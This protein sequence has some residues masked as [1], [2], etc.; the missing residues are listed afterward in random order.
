MKRKLDFFFKTLETPCSLTEF[1]PNDRVNTKLR[2]QSAPKPT[3]STEYYGGR[4]VT[5]FTE[6]V[7]T[8][9]SNL[10]QQS[11]SPNANKSQLSEASYQNN[12]TTDIT[13]WLKGFLNPQRNSSY[14][15]S[16]Q[17]NGNAKL[18]ISPGKSSAGKVINLE[19]F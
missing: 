4:G 13:V 14:E 6:N 18:F 2:C 1:Y 9:F 10:E 19:Q 15:F 8:S 16:L 11:P 3:I 17:T 12:Q 5:I 7:L